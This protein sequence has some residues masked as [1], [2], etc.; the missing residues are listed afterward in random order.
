MNFSLQTSR[1][2]NKEIRNV[3][4]VSSAISF[5]N[6]AERS[7]EE[8][9]LDFSKAIKFIQTIY[10]TTSARH[11]LIANIHRDQQESDSNCEQDRHDEYEHRD[12]AAPSAK[13]FGFIQSLMRIV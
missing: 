10:F 13:C 4:E 3:E 2:S 7:L 9:F 12:L 11:F 8:E 5:C 6:L 1:N